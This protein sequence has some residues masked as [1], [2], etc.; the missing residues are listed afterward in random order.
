VIGEMFGGQHRDDEVTRTEL[1]GWT[2]TRIRELW[3]IARQRKQ[4]DRTAAE[5]CAKEIKNT[6]NT[7]D[8]GRLRNG[9]FTASD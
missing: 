5:V 4:R 8:R 3:R 2:G 9:F 7:L 1:V 6:L